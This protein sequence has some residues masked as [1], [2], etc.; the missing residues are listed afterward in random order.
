MQVAHVRFFIA[1]IVKNNGKTNI[2][3]EI[4]KGLCFQQNL[5]KLNCL[6][7][8]KCKFRIPFFFFFPTAN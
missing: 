1:T 4:L 6:N 2:N 3:N 8:I 7:F 5:S